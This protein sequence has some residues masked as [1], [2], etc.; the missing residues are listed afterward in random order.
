[1]S[2][3]TAVLLDLDGTLYEH[4]ELVP[5]APAILAE[6]R[7]RGLTLRFV[8]NTDSRRAAHVLEAAHRMRLD[9]R[10][11]E[12]W[13]PARALADYLAGIPDAQCFLLLSPQLCT[14]FAPYAAEDDVTHVVV[15]GSCTNI[16]H[17]R[18]DSAFRHLR[19][20]AR[21]VTT[22]RSAWCVRR[23]GPYLDAGAYVA[24]F[25]AATGETAKVLGKPSRDFFR[26]VLHDIG[27]G[28]REVLVV[29]DDPLT[30]I[31][32]G[33]AVGATTVLVRTGKG[34][35]APAAA[36]PS[37]NHV[38]DSIRDLPQLLAGYYDS[39]GSISGASGWR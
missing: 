27:R 16:T 32:G 1:M 25:E 9:I 29:G 38:V 11:P 21:L 35:Y 34:R 7:Q 6:L 19:V 30:D 24:L 15:G 26:A 17:H 22:H 23:D 37:P 2:A 13:T 8:T 4:G 5:G 33:H 18:L 28:G 20:G 14:D 10:A 3:P 36:A 39:L 31:A 12:L